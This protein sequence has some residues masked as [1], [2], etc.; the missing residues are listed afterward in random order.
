M[1]P[2]THCT[3][4]DITTATDAQ[5]RR[6]ST[7]T[8]STAIAQAGTHRPPR[9]GHRQDARVHRN[10]ASALASPHHGVRSPLPGSVRVPTTQRADDS[11]VTCAP[12]GGQ[13]AAQCMAAC[14]PPPR[15]AVGVRDGA[16]PR[17]STP[18]APHATAQQLLERPAVAAPTAM[19]ADLKENAEAVHESVLFDVVC[20][21]TKYLRSSVFQESGNG[22][23]EPCRP[24]V[25]LPRR[26][27][28]LRMHQLW[29]FA[30]PHPSLAA[31]LAILQHTQSE[32][33]GLKKTLATA[34]EECMQN[35]LLST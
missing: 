13:Q 35:R 10:H 33:Q 32:S 19:M 17:P 3:A 2:L 8:S 5:R 15:G 9:D 26:I 18:F 31:W 22:H 27:K 25:A 23:R 20:S 12:V 30:H 14:P 4:L 6:G 34:K 1:D 16:V 11:P 24:F 29:D 21:A 7:Q 28:L